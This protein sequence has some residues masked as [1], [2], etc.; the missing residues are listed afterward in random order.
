M[1]RAPVAEARSRREDGATISLVGVPA[2]SSDLVVLV[3]ADI[4]EQERRRQAEREFVTNASHE[5]RT[6]VT[7]IIERRRGAPVGAR[8]R[9][10]RARALHR[11]DRPPGHAADAALQLAADPRAR[12]DPAGE[13]APRPVELGGRCCEIAAASV[14]ADGV[15]LRV[16]S[17]RRARRRRRAARHR[18]AGRREPRRQRDQAHSSRA[19][20]CC[21]PRWTAANGATIEVADTGPGISPPCSAASSTASTAARCSAA[22]ASVSGSRLRATRPSRDRAARSDRVRPRPRHDRARRLAARRG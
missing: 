3:F 15:S 21:A 17:A 12:A 20:S 5:L 1:P 8:G 11:P 10:G 14:P 9:T 18:R 19:R 22:T 13:P 4:T 16:E 7:A 2:S 6:P